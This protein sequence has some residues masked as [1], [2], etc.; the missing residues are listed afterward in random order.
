MIKKI[1]FMS[2]VIFGTGLCAMNENARIN[3]VVR[4]KPMC[5]GKQSAIELQVQEA[6]SLRSTL[7]D[8]LQA[9]SR[10]KNSLLAFQVKS[11]VETG[12]LDDLEAF[13]SDKNLSG[14]DTIAN[15]PLLTAINVNKKWAIMPLAIAGAPIAIKDLENK[16]LVDVAYEQ[17]RRPSFI[18]DF[19]KAKQMHMHKQAASTSYS[20]SSSLSTMF[21]S[22][23]TRSTPVPRSNAVS[24]FCYN[25]DE[26]I[27]EDLA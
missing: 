8:E 2:L 13:L 14:L 20:S 5:E 26:G 22:L 27:L 7:I 6:L 3:R 11:I 10:D 4:C 18:E 17:K 25:G 19:L 9:N 23:S 15:N 16:D 24:P 21:N 12:S 1:I